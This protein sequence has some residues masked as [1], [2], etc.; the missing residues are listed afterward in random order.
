MS[1]K[2][3]GI[4]L[5]PAL[6]FVAGCVL[7]VLV[8]PRL[9]A[10]FIQLSADPVNRAIL[11]GH[12]PSAD[13]LDR[14]VASRRQ[15]SAWV[16]DSRAWFEIGRARLAGAAGAG[17]RTPRG[18]AGL[19]R[20]GAAYDRGLAG[21]PGNAIAWMRL[22]EIRLLRAGPSPAAAAAL[23]MSIRTAPFHFRVMIERLRLSFL[24]W[25]HFDAR[26]RRA[27]VRQ[28]RIASRN[29][30]LSPR[31]EKLAATPEVAAALMPVMEKIAAEPAAAISRRLDP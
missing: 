30:W 28:V 6:G 10:A 7:L 20:A 15:A 29:R 13:A 9:N 8:T 19:D 12:T 1:T 2:S 27:V 4:R 16:E 22:G 23:Y 21:S 14:L 3:R 26:G 25:P 5:V 11:R 17:Y 31:L 18:R 24:V